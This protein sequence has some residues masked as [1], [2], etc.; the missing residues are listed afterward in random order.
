[1]TPRQLRREK[2][3]TDYKKFLAEEAKKAEEVINN[4]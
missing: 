1:M 3:K 2:R 4:E